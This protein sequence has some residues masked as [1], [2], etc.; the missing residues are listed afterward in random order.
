MK[1][2]CAGHAGTANR[3]ASAVSEAPRGFPENPRRAAS[4]LHECL[5]HRGQPLRLVVVDVVSGVVDV[6]DLEVRV[7][8]RTVLEVLRRAGEPG[9]QPG[10][11]A[12][13][14]QHRGTGL[15]PA[16]DRLRLAERQRVD[17]L[18]RGIGAAHDAA[19]GCEPAPVL[20]QEAGPR[21]GQARVLRAHP[22]REFLEALV[23]PLRRVVA[24]LGQPLREAPGG[25]VLTPAGRA[26]AVDVDE[27]G[28]AIRTNAGI[29]GADVGAHAVADQA[30]GHLRRVALEQRVEVADMVGQP[31]AVGPAPARQ[32]VAAPVGGDDLPV[33]RERI[34][35]ELPGGGHV[36]R[37]VQQEQPRR[38][39]RPP[40]AAMQLDA[41]DRH[42]FGTT[43]FHGAILLARPGA[44]APAGYQAAPGRIRSPRPARSSPRDTSRRSRRSS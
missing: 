17:A 38:A 4:C 43:G 33:L 21:L 25:R 41:A 28:D 12:I 29:E 20:D 3:N 15:A 35:G 2:Q 44:R 30:H 39:G 32:A 24:E 23:A 26:E 34:D 19:V 1:T 37:A 27:A 11:R 31:V 5:D 22:Q 10:L 6:L 40:D 8:P 7:G 13:D 16:V 42:E 9:P 18:E 14:P 36:L